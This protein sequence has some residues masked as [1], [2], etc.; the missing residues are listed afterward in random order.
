MRATLSITIAI[1]ALSFL[2]PASGLAETGRPQLWFEVG[3][4]LHYRIYWGVIYVGDSHVTTEWIEEDGRTLLRIRYR[5]R[6]NSFL[7]RIYPVDDTIEAVIE[8]HSF[9]PVRFEKRLSEG[10]YRADEVT[11]FDHAAGKAY[12]TNRRKNITKEFD[13]EPDTRDIVTFMYFMR[14]REFLP[15]EEASFRVMA[16]EKIYDLFIKAGPVETLSMP[17]YGKVKSIRIVPE[18]AFQGLFVRKGRMTLWVSQDARRVATRI[19]AS[20]PV[21]NVHVNLYQVRGPGNDFW[22]QGGSKWAEDG[23]GGDARRPETEDLA[24]VD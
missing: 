8:P 1:W 3:E 2:L 16:D 17:K 18:A 4:E 20:V 22:V 6:S 13:I 10:R 7:D 14:Q 21:A 15:G 19:Q 24:H 9:L 11:V 23:A 5:T 12:W